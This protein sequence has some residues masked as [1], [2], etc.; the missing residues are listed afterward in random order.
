MNGASPAR[1]YHVR[2]VRSSTVLRTIACSLTAV[3]SMTSPSGVTNSENPV[4]DTC[5]SQRPVSM[6]RK[7][8]D[9]TCWVCRIVPV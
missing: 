7:R 8:L 1:T 4:G 9:E 3:R 5:T 2:P 6:A